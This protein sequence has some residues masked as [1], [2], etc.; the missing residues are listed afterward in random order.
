M[1]SDEIIGF[2]KPHFKFNVTEQVDDDNMGRELTLEFSKDEGITLKQIEGVLSKHTSI[3]PH[4]VM[5]MNIVA[6]LIDSNDAHIV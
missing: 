5:S 4:I 1:T 2:L 3:L 6:I